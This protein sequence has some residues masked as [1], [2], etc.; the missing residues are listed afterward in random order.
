MV[1]MTD[2]WRSQVEAAL[3]A[4]VAVATLAQTTLSP[5]QIEV[6]FLDAP[7]T[8][9]SSLPAGRMAVYGYWGNGAWL[10]IG[11]AGPKSQARYTSQHYS[12]RS[13]PSTLAKSLAGDGRMLSCN[14]FDARAPAGW[15]KSSCHRVNILLPME[16]GRDVLAL[17]EAFLHVRLKPRYER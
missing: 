15:I 16:C 5:A 10:K 1:H 11:I 3:D 6:T 17:L 12:L 8:P 7:H 2:D 4:F 13:A 14:G 9:P